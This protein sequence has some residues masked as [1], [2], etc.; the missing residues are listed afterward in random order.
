[1]STQN[2]QYVAKTYTNTKNTENTENKVIIEEIYKLISEAAI[3]QKNTNFLY[4]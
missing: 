1:M 3:L 2:I 4:F